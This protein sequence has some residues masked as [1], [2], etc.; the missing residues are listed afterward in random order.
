MADTWQREEDP[1]QVVVDNNDL[2]V[3]FFVEEDQETQTKKVMCRLSVFTTQHC[4]EN[5]K[6]SL[7]VLEQA[8]IITQAEHTGL[9]NVLVKIRDGGL[10]A[11]GYTKL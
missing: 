2:E 5:I 1:T 3:H 4:R 11:L 10:Q 8:G 6:R 7:D 9:L